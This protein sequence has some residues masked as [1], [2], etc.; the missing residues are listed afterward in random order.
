MTS[1]NF[2]GYFWLIK[3]LSIYILGSTTN[4]VSNNEGTIVPFPRIHRLP[5]PHKFLYLT[6]SCLLFTMYKDFFDCPPLLDVN[7]SNSFVGFRG[8]A[9]AA[10]GVSS[11][12]VLS[13]VIAL[14]RIF[15]L[16]SNAQNAQNSIADLPKCRFV[17]QRPCW[18]CVCADL[19]KSCS[20]V[21]A[22][23]SYVHSI[24]SGRCR[25]SLVF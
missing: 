12:S 17:L 10:A 13:S 21:V 19:P 14:R 24:E 2:I 25:I 6:T 15:I 16:S 9:S 7:F 22:F 3:H 5:P 8:S 20:F 11:S 18:R 4:D 1:R 23:S